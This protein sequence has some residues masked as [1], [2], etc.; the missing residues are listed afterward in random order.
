MDKASALAMFKVYK[1]E[2][3]NQLDRK[4]KIVSSNHGGEIY[5]YDETSDKGPFAIIFK[6]GIVAQYTVHNTPKHNQ[7]TKKNRTVTDIVRSTTSKT[8]LSECLR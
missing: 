2:V 3:K 6:N 8:N 1:I 7:W 5:R 4:I